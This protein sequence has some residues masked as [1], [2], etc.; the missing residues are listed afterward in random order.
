MTG[1][2][3]V[4]LNRAIAPAMVD[5]PA[6]GLAL[7]DGARRAGWPVTTASPPCAAHLLEW[8]ADPHEAADRATWRRTAAP[9]ASPSATTSPPR[10]HASAS[11][12]PDGAARS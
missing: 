3:M 9:P 5:G 12:S 7:L 6:R 8:P 1:N 2:P 10:P 4:T 11:G